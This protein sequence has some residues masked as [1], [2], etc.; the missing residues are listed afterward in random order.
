MILKLRHNHGIFSVKTLEGRNLIFQF[1]KK[2]TTLQ[3]IYNLIFDKI[4][5]QYKG[6][7]NKFSF[8]IKIGEKYWPDDFEYVSKKIETEFLDKL[9]CSNELHNGNKPSVT[10]CL[11]PNYATHKNTKPK[12]T[13]FITTKEINDNNKCFDDVNFEYELINNTMITIYV[14]TMTSKVIS[15]NCLPNYTI[16]KLKEQIEDKDKIPCCQQRLVFAGKQLDD[17][18]SLFEYNICNND[19]LHLIL[20]LR[21]GM[22]T[23]CSGRSGKY[24]PIFKDIFYDITTDTFIELI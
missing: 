11:V 17:N 1:E 16:K 19:S 14:K 3:D 15:I 24:L 21:G 12:F 22:Y 20:S 13:T 5:Y 9:D 4:K 18:C 2:M 7:V 8:K 6:D 23:E 10:V